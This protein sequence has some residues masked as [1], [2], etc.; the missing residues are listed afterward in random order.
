MLQKR[1]QERELAEFL[2][3]FTVTGRAHVADDDKPQYTLKSV[4][5]PS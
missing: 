3:R 5:T 4:C 2:Q 1:E